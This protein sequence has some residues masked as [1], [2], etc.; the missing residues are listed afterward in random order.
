[1]R[2]SWMVLC[3]CLLILKP[4]IADTSFATLKN[5]SG[6]VMI[7]NAEM[8]TK[9]TLN[10]PLYSGAKIVTKNGT[11]LVLF[12][13]GATLQVDPFSSIRAID[14]IEDAK[15]NSPEPVKIRSI[16]ILLGRTKYEEQ[17]VP[18]RQTII[19]LPTAVAALR[20]TA[21]WFGADP[22]TDSR[23]ILT[24]GNMDTTGIFGNLMP[25][26]LNLAMALSSPTFAASLNS[27]D[28]ANNPLSNIQEIQAELKTL[29]ANPDPRIQEMI[30]QTMAVI[31]PAIEGIERKLE[32]AKASEAEKALSDKAVA[33]ATSDTKAQVTETHKMASQASQVLVDT[34]QESTKSDIFLVLETMKGNTSGIAIAQR[35]KETNDQALSLAEKAV[36]T[37]VSAIAMATAATSETQL[38]TALT[39]AKTAAQTSR[40]VQEVTKTTNANGALLIAGNTDGL[41][42]IDRL[43]AATEKS[44]ATAEKIL[45]VAQI[46]VLQTDQ[47]LGLETAQKAE[48]A[49]ETLQGEAIKRSEAVQAIMNKSPNAEQLINIIQSTTES[50]DQTD[51]MLDNIIK[52]LVPEKEEIPEEPEAYTQPDAE[53][54]A[55]PDAEPYTQPY[56][57]IRA[58]SPT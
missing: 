35:I 42:Q 25:K 32:T 49:A 48:T 58:A 37:A 52:D 46:A 26:I 28:Q 55:Q 11:A 38:N 29:V 2:L 30:K 8:W 12:Q 24:E 10:M 1:M 16:R 50:S 14:Q 6:E 19:E 9:P 31:L 44:L 39:I 21:G 4:A 7:K 15:A 5:F 45:Q 57:D 41:A 20:G 23:I 43:S 56:D 27:A 34:V 18:G 22:N 33:A 17:P 36:K 47:E 51:K 13:D 53:P 40:A 54:Y 3:C